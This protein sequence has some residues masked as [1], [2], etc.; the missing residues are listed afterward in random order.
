[1][2]KPRRAERVKGP[3]KAVPAAREYLPAGHLPPAGGEPNPPK[4]RPLFLL[5]SAVAVALWL[6]FLLWMA[7]R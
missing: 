3:T 7:I 6:V 1:M 2:S 4:R 5:A